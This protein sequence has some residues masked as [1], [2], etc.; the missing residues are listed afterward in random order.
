MVP[1]GHGLAH[2]CVCTDSPCPLTKLPKGLIPSWAQLKFFGLQKGPDMHCP[3]LRRVLLILTGVCCKEMGAVV[4]HEQLPLLCPHTGAI[5]PVCTQG[6]S[7]LHEQGLQGFQLTHQPFGGHV[8]SGTLPCM[9][10]LWGWRV[11]D[12]AHVGKC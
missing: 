6:V 11:S 5:V 7:P 8:C 9:C 3:G 10:I 4:V 1:Q 2:V 12:C